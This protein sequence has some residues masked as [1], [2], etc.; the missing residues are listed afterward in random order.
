M[1]IIDTRRLGPRYLSPENIH[2]LVPN[3][4]FRERLV[5]RGELVGLAQRRHVVPE[6]A[7]STR[8]VAFPK[9]PHP[10]H[11]HVRG[12]VAQHHAGNVM[13]TFLGRRVIR[14][15]EFEKFVFLER[16]RAE[17]REVRKT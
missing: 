8:L 1:V 7:V 12:L 3:R 4:L 6:V 16:K 2:P 17:N 15:F 11:P 13:T 14:F 9:A 5:V 10:M